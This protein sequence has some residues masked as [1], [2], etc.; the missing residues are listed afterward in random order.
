MYSCSVSETA[1][2]FSLKC[3]LSEITSKWLFSPNR[4]HLSCKKLKIQCDD[5]RSW[6]TSALGLLP[7]PSCCSSVS[8]T[9]GFW[10]ALLLLLPCSFCLHSNLVSLLWLS[11]CFHRL[12]SVSCFLY[13]RNHC[14]FSHGDLFVTVGAAQ[15]FD[16]SRLAFMH[17]LSYFNLVFSPSW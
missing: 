17:S 7:S 6:T 3:P 2:Y 12:T 14:V 10:Q 15:L 4:V 1:T 9:H 16:A 8:Q 11:S 5:G 13:C